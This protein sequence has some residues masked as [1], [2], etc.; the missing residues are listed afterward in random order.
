MSK[1]G[2]KQCLSTDELSY[3]LDVAGLQKRIAVKM[4]KIL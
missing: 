4:N 1:V 3:L 2:A